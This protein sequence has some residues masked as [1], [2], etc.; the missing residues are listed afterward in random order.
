MIRV[1]KRSGF[2]RITSYMKRNV[3]NYRY[4]KRNILVALSVVGVVA[5]TIGVAKLG[6][7]VD[8]DAGYSTESTVEYADAAFMKEGSITVAMGDSG[9]EDVL[10]ADNDNDMVMDAEEESAF[11]DKFIVKTD[12]ILNVRAEASTDSELTG[13]MEN[14]AVGD[15]T[16]TEGEW[17]AISSGNVTGYVKTEYILTGAEAEEYAAD[18]VQVT[19]TINTDTVRVR[20]EA[21]TDADILALAA[22]DTVLPVISEEDDWVQVQLSDTETGYVM[23]DYIDVETTYACALTLAEYDALYNTQEDEADD[24]EEAAAS[25]STDSTS[26]DSSSS[27]SSTSDSQSSDSTTSDSTSSG[28]SSDS[29]SSSSQTE[30]TTTTQTETSATVDTS[31]Y[32]DAY[33]LACLISMEAGYESYEGQLAVANVVLNRLHSGK[34]GSTIADV[35]YAPNQ[36]PCATGSVMQ[37]YLENGPLDM[38]LQAANDALNG[39]NNIGSFMSFLNQKYVDTDSLSD[40]IIIGNHCFY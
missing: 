24:T 5:M 29:T 37:G 33:L 31:Q 11:D 8:Q 6:E 34:W 36:F 13:K 40:Y 27:D 2:K 32:S 9:S 39:N 4:I 7:Q 30:D 16:G 1:S 10:V 22:I 35:I 18:Y 17:T 25:V 38:A 26:S 20:S 15:I 23:S 3:L 21:S 14:G 19:G 12:D 28:S